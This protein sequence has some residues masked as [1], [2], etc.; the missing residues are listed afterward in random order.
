MEIVT[1]SIKQA[2]NITGFIGTTIILC[3]SRFRE[4][5]EVYPLAVL[6]VRVPVEGVDQT[7]GQR[8]H[9]SGYPEKSLVSG[10][11]CHRSESRYVIVTRVSLIGRKSPRTRRNSIRRRN[12]SEKQRCRKSSSGSKLF[13]FQRI[14]PFEFSNL[15]PKLLHREKGPK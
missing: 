10:I 3:I 13:Q 12:K 2:F 15:P 8:E 5:A 11:F 14:A 7:E 6:Q 9:H 4:C 1:S